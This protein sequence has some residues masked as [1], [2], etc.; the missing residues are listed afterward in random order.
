MRG[1]AGYPA[2]RWWKQ[3]GGGTNSKTRT[4]NINCK[5]IVTTVQ[6]YEPKPTNEYVSEGTQLSIE[7]GQ[8]S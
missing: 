4:V 7:S 6:V 1:G 8:K 2:F 3:L 5:K